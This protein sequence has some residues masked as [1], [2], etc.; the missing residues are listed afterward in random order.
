MFPWDV[1]DVDGLLNTAAGFRAAR[2]GV[3]VTADFAAESTYAVS[4]KL[5]GIAVFVR[6]GRA[7]LVDWDVGFARFVSA[8]A[9][10]LEA[11]SDCSRF[12]VGRVQFGPSPLGGTVV[13]ASSACA[14]HS[15]FM[16]ASVH[17]WRWQPAPLELWITP[18]LLQAL[19]D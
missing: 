16:L 1:D 4:R 9:K 10:R 13:I 7:D 3:P 17:G 18:E 5:C 14:G 12:S 2:F 8:A 6:G 15:C 11:Y 19:A